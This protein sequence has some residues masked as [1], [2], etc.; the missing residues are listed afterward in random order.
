MV[1]VVA[2]TTC[3]KWRNAY[4]TANGYC[5]MGV[6]DKDKENC[7]SCPIGEAW[8]CKLNCDKWQE[9]RNKL[10]E[11]KK[12]FMKVENNMYID[13]V[14]SI[15]LPRLHCGRG[16]FS[17]LKYCLYCKLVSK[18]WFVFIHSDGCGG[19]GGE[20]RKVRLGAKKEEWKRKIWLDRGGGS[21]N[22]FIFLA[23]EKLIHQKFIPCFWRMVDVIHWFILWFVASFFFSQKKNT[24]SH[25]DKRHAM[26][27]SNCPCF[28]Y[29]C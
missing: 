10:D 4:V 21:F 14:T 15:H 27:I 16:F 11:I 23:W 18:K 26:T 20:M 13:Y 28:M 25:A 9:C 22:S 5:I 7:T 8:T 19:G 17:R 12:R 6:K 24:N 3:C 1:F 2:G 29:N